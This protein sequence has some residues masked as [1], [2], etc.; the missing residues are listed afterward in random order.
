MPKKLIFLLGAPTQ[1][2]LQWDEEQLLKEP[3]FPFK[4]PHLHD[5]ESWRLTD[6]QPV[7]WRLLQ[8]LRTSELLQGNSDLRP[9][10]LACFLTTSDL[11]VSGGIS[12]NESEGSALSRFYEHSFTVHE[13]S[14]ISTAGVRSGDSFQGSSLWADSIGSSIATVSEKEAPSPGILFHGSVT[15]LQDIPTAAYLNSI[16]PQ[17]M[18]VNLVVSIMTIHPPRRI[19]TR[20]WKK[21]L[22]LV[23]V[24]VGDD[25]RSGFG[26]TFWLPAADQ[27]HT[28]D[29]LG[30]SLATLRPRDIILMRTVGL[31][32]FRE[33]VYGQ[34]LRKGVTKVD[35]LHRQRVDANDAGGVYSAKR[36]REFQ[37]QQQ[38]QQQQGPAAKNE[39]DLLVVKVNE[40][41]EWIRRFAPDAAGG[42]GSK[43]RPTR[44]LAG[45]A[46]NGGV[47]ALPPDTQEYN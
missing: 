1:T 34:S 15:N 44:G 5:G 39:E 47:N 13:V 31:S 7:K 33:R 22:D 14:E 46:T 30:K 9:R 21:E 18:T 45:T 16:V 17:T 38:Q 10:R 8:D 26:V 41:R 40:V 29:E 20:Q 28:E 3:I 36:L 43:G 6:A 2:G 32:S 35:L 23:E 37:Q 25:T 42:D 12:A 19:V 27:A 4:D 11:T 24:V